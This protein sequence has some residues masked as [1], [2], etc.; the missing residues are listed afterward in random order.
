[1]FDTSGCC[2]VWFFFLFF[3]T[4]FSKFQ[5]E[6][7]ELVGCLRSLQMIDRGFLSIRACRVF[8]RSIHVHWKGEEKRRERSVF[9]IKIIIWG[10]LFRPSH[11][12]CWF[13]LLPCTFTDTAGVCR[14]SCGHAIVSVIVISFITLPFGFCFFGGTSSWQYGDSITCARQR[15]RRRRLCCGAYSFVPKRKCVT[16]RL[17][18]RTFL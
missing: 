17:H 16:A 1:M 11:S 4:S 13:S 5:H 12:P 9:F 7:G 6:Q 10:L 3:F 15:R 14:W 2:G 18:S 8:S